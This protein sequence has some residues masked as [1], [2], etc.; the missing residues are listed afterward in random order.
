[1]KAIAKTLCVVLLAAMFPLLSPSVSAQG[2]EAQDLH[3]GVQADFL[4]LH[5]LMQKLQALRAKTSPEESKTLGVGNRYIQEKELHNEMQ[6]IKD[7]IAAESYD[8]AHAKMKAVST[9]LK[10]LLDLLLNRDLDLKKLLEEI[11]RLEDYKKRVDSIIKDQQAEKNDAAKSEN[12]ENQLRDLEEAKAKVSQL[13]EEQK[14]LRDATAKQNDLSAEPEKAKQMAAKQAELKKATEALA[15]KLSKLEKKAAKSGDAKSGEPK[16]SK[17]AK[18]GE[19]KPSESKP[20]ESKPKAGESKAGSCSGSCKSASKSMGKSKKKLEKSQPKPSLED[21]DKAIESL[22]KALEELEEMSEEAKRKLLALPFEQQVRAQ[23]KTKYDTDKLAKDMEKAEEQGDEAEAPKKTPG[24]KNIQQAVPKQKAAAGQLKE[25]KPGK[26]KQDQQDAIDDLKKAQKKLEDAL[27]QL[28]QQLQDEVLRALEERFAA[29]LAKQKEISA[30]TKAAFRLQERSLV[31]AGQVPAAVAKRCTQLSEGE[32]MLSAEA[33][34]ALKLLE[35]DGTTAIFEY[36]VGDVKE[37][38]DTIGERLHGNKCAKVTQDI[39]QDVEDALRELIDSLRKQIEMKEG[40]CGDC[41]GGGPPPLVPMSAELKLVMGRQKR[42][43]KRTKRFD[44][45]VPEAKRVSDEAK[46]ASTEIAR[47]QNNVEF[48]MRKLAQ[49]LS[50]EAE[51]EEG[52]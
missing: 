48:L 39:Q 38:L 4:K 7:L 42:V 33:S 30:L 37:D 18:P 47:Q 44:T 1:M 36:V 29:M 8:E 49:K 24:K 13:L 41:K 26:A 25:Y 46:D 35:E 52:K 27:A 40:E 14:D 5:Q 28:R 17:P 45:A 20:S 51:S 6:A 32:L 19:A 16:E 31:A 50:K 23:E 12:L 3:Q 34:D 9:E 11:A 21:Q 2:K 22:E 15:K 10:Q 43:N